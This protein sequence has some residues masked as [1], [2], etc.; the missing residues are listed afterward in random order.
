MKLR[1][2]HISLGIFFLWL[3]PVAV[4]G[5]V[6]VSSIMRELE[7]SPSPDLYANNLDFQVFAFILTKGLVAVL[8]LGLALW[9]AAYAYRSNLLPKWTR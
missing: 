2:R 6:D 4:Y 7:T 8:L 1:L 9:S 3:V 5:Y